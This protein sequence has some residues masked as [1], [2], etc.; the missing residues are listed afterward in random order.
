M[1]TELTDNELIAEFMGMTS[2]FDTYFSKEQNCHF[3]IKDFKYD[4][5][6][7]WLMPV[8]EKI[9]H[10]SEKVEGN[11]MHLAYVS[12]HVHITCIGFQAKWCCSILGSITYQIPINKTQH[13]YKTINVPHI[14][15]YAEDS[16]E[17]N[18]AIIPTYKAVVEFI[19]WY[20]KSTKE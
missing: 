19:K 2:S 20:N 10:F 16:F 18:K 11:I 3:E 14:T 8:V 15:I 7:D 4:T 17:K 9:Q 5:S 1:K 12:I 13:T 6:W